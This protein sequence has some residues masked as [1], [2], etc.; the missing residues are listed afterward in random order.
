MEESCTGAFVAEKHFFLLFCAVVAY[1]MLRAYTTH[2]TWLCSFFSFNQAFSGD[3]TFDTLSIHASLY[4]LKQQHQS[5]KMPV[6][7]KGWE[8]DSRE[9]NRGPSV[10]RY[11]TIW[12]L[13]SADAKADSSVASLV[14]IPVP[15]HHQ[16]I[17]AVIL[18]SVL[19]N[20]YNT[21]VFLDPPAIVCLMNL[22]PPSPVS[23]LAL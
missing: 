12:P 17:R 19:L 6:A 23:S 2:A 15:N 4:P 13:I 7:L 3:Q 10:V 9:K 20:I 14:A 8:W 11:N 16:W 5:R 22:L 18:S 1:S 21:W